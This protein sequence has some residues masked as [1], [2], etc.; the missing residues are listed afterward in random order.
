MRQVWAG[1]G[2]LV[3]VLLCG[4]TSSKD[5]NAPA[6]G[7]LTPDVDDGTRRF[8]VIGDFGDDNLV[9]IGIGGEDKVAELIDGWN[10]DFVV[11]AGDNNYPNGAASTIDANIGKYF[12][13]FIGDYTGEYGSGSDTNR[14]WPTPGNHDWKDPGLQAYLD[15]FTLPGN[16]RYYDVQLGLVHLF[17]LDSES[18]E[19]DGADRESIQAQWFQ[20]TA[21]ESTSCFKLVV[22]HRPAFSSGKHGSSDRM[23]WP[24]AEWGMDAVIAAHDHIYERIEHEGIPYFVNGLGGSLKYS[25]GE[26]VENSEAYY[27][28]NFGAQLV[29]VT[30]ESMLLEFYNTDG[31]LIDSRSID[32]NCPVAEAP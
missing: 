4:C 20:K 32:K 9:S 12:S 18:D 16:E 5:D 22:F 24:F 2:S 13:V 15:Y 23:Q 26:E 1:L 25:K 19:P 21:S 28:D 14:F 11:T 29:T 27:Q 31:E 8:A 6:P 7:P 17:A 30:N 3:L 10:V